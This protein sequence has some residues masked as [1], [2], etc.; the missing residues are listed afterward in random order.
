MIFGETTVAVFR[1]KRMTR[2][3][4]IQT[5]ALGLVLASGVAN[6]GLFSK[7][8]KPAPPPPPEPIP[9]VVVPPPPPP[10]PIPLEFSG[11][12]TAVP[13]PA[14][15]DRLQAA[16]PDVLDTVHWIESTKDNAGLPFVV[17]DKTNAQVYAFTPYAQL[18]ATSPVL[19]GGGVGDVALVPQDAPM[20]AMP[21]EKR[22]TPAGRYLSKLV[23][24]NHGKVV[25][26][27][28]GANLITMHIVAKGTPAQR[29]A[30]RL[31]S[32][33]S[34][35]NRVSFGCIN[36]PPAF[37]TSVV[38]PD[39]RPGKGIVYIL[40]EKQTPGQL[41]GF[42]PVPRP[43]PSLAP[44]L[45]TAASALAS[46]QSPQA[47]Q[48]VQSTPAVMVPAATQTLGAATQARVMLQ[49]PTPAATQTLGAA[50]QARVML[51]APTSAAM[52]PA[53]VTPA[54][55]FTP[56]ASYVPVVSPAQHAP[57]APPAAPAD[58]TTA[59]DTTAAK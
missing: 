17:V 30:E 46:M 51:Q 40:P 32:V 1:G 39:F 33:T 55:T 19:L 43:A 4:T 24:D 10:A 52:V 47:Q 5:L 41:F 8:A 16:S 7:K 49:A 23:I 35:D 54:A 13:L 6:A 58:G 2:H 14:S 53:A 36:V 38:D 31:A 42:Q 34:T 56:P 25:L 29:R 3:T 20:S 44:E 57:V 21:P 12:Q 18:K 22:I 26:L 45:G 11:I 9:V 50:T 37:F 27:V 15:M 28:D 48:A 59:G